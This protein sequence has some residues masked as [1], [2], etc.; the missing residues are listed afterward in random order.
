MLVGWPE[1]DHADERQRQPDTDSDSKSDGD[2][3]GNAALA[4]VVVGVAVHPASMVGPPKS[5]AAPPRLGA[6][7]SGRAGGAGPEQVEPVGLGPEPGGR[8]DGADPLGEALLDS[9][10]G[11]EVLD[12]TTADAHEVVVVAAGEF[13][14]ELEARVLVPADHA[15]HDAGLLQDR[16]VAVSGAL[17]EPAVGADQF[18]G[19]DGPVCASQ[20]VDEGVAPGCVALLDPP[21]AN[22]GENVQVVGHEASVPR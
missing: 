4:R 12:G 20:R 21:E 15:P 9:T 18:R 16:E 2:A 5:C 1:H 3:A 19:G 17:G 6:G 10:R 22:G 7:R 8:R 13:L 14:C 11:I